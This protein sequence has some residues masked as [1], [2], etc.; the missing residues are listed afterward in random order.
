MIVKK[1][2]QGSRDSGLRREATRVINAQQKEGPESETDKYKVSNTHC[3]DSK[4]CSEV[5]LRS[6]LPVFSSAT[7]W[8]VRTSV[9]TAWKLDPYRGG[10]AEKLLPQLHRTCGQ[11]PGAPNKPSALPCP[12][13]TA[14]LLA[15]RCPASQPLGL[16]STA[17]PLTNAGS[18]RRSFLLLLL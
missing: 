4:L 3:L 14:G 1:G 2:G 5:S 8:T 10:M 18:F 13:V 16:S 17:A 12:A 6:A 15:Q 9:R 11:H 7:L